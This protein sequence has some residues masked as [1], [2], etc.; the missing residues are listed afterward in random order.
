M[1]LNRPVIINGQELKNTI[2]YVNGEFVRKEEAKISVYDSGFQHGDGVYEGIRVYNDKLFMLKEHVQRLYESCKTLDIKIDLSQEELMEIVKET[3]RKNLDAGFKDLHIR[4]QVTRGLKGMT[5]MNPKMNLTEYSLVICVDEKK[6][7]F[8]K[9]GIKLI[10][11]TLLRFSPQYLDAKIH[12]CNQLNQI[13][14]AIEANRQGAAEAIMLDA[15]GFVAETNSTTLVMVKDGQFLLPKID[16]ILP[17]ITR[18]ILIEIARSNN[19][20]TIERNISV[21][22]FYNADEVFICGT[23]GEIV[24]VYE[25][26]GRTISTNTDNKYLNIFREGYSELIKEY[27]SE[28]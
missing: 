19:I 7:I 15:N 1:N 6:P 23:V 21:S 4:L 9:E 22:E 3:V 2:I 13:M 8:N 25:I 16:Y 14:A 20:P 11:A 27:A 17:G 5:G 26:D 24:P 28:I 10:T 12:S 18:K